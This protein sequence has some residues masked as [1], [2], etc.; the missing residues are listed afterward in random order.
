ML[1]LECD[2]IGVGG[3]RRTVNRTVHAIDAQCVDVADNS[4]VNPLDHLLSG[5][6]MT[7][8]E[9]DADF[10]ALALGGLGRLEPSADGGAI[11]RQGIFHQT[12]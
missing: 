5:L 12:H 8:H 2:L 9:A 6:G 11:G 1:Q 3:Q 7:P 10:Q 4:I